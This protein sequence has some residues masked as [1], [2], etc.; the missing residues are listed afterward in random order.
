MQFFNVALQLVSKTLSKWAKRP[1]YALK[2]S[3]LR[4][5]DEILTTEIGFSEPYFHDFSITKFTGNS[6]EK[7]A[8]LKRIYEFYNSIVPVKLDV[9]R[10]D[11]PLFRL[12]FKKNK[13]AEM[14]Y[15]MLIRGNTE[16]MVFA[17]DLLEQRGGKITRKWVPVSAYRDSPYVVVKMRTNIKALMELHVKTSHR[18]YRFAGICAH[19]ERVSDGWE[20][21]CKDRVDFDMLYVP[22]TDDEGRRK[23][24]E[25]FTDEPDEFLEIR[26]QAMKARFSS[27]TSKPVLYPSV[28]RE[29]SMEVACKVVV[30]SMQPS[31]MVEDKLATLLGLVPGDTVRV[32]IKKVV[33]LEATEGVRES[34][35][36]YGFYETTQQVIGGLIVQIDNNLL[37]LKNFKSAMMVVATFKKV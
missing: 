28:A 18:V 36:E 25:H 6:K 24:Y 8:L 1:V 21:Y 12:K 9:V 11:P 19:W 32:D 23:V 5:S 2:T 10:M 3:V 17:L 33:D 31:L 15:E 16:N 26:K 29:G 37:A 34:K 20:I 22:I 13:D 7:I 14:I 30:P 27:L 35:F 4:D